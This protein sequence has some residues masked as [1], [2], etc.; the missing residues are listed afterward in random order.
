[1]GTTEVIMEVSSRHIQDIHFTKA[2]RGYD[3]DEVDRFMAECALHTGNLEERTK[4]AEVRSETAET[5]LAEM[6]A[7]IDILLEEATDARRKIIE[8][9]RQEAGAI[10][11]QASEAG[12]PRGTEDTTTGVEEQAAEIVRQ[13]EASATIALANA[14]R[15]L[16][17][18]RQESESIL[19]EARTSKALMESQLAEIRQILVAARSNDESKPELDSSDDPDA[20]L[21][22]DLRN[23]AD[24]PRTNQVSG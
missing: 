18:A 4:I 17:D 13:A 7:N 23:M 6:R 20:E 15:I 21:V 2:L 10:T 22:V 5:E 16:A 19:E 1:M 8:E 12:W 14:D 24:E 9:A 3:R 11:S